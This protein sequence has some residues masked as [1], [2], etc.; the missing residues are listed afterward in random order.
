M[1]LI[2]D[3]FVPAYTDPRDEEE[4]EELIKAGISNSTWRYFRLKKGFT[5]PGEK[6][7]K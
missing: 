4:T 3:G 2:N 7:F 6:V 1:A 5:L